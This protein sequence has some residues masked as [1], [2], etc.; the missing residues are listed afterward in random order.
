MMSGLSEI[1]KEWCTPPPPTSTCM[2]LPNFQLKFRLQ[3]EV[4]NAGWLIAQ[5]A[6]RSPCHGRGIPCSV[7]PSNMRL[8]SEEKAGWEVK[9]GCPFYSNFSRWRC[10]RWRRRV[11]L[12]RSLTGPSREFFFLSSVLS[13][14]LVHTPIIINHHHQ[15]N[16]FHIC[17]IYIMQI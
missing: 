3:E 14:S 9:L 5:Q 10:C 15:K 2:C 6:C 7:K 11:G 17:V 4:S 8:P 13:A 1:L 12:L 16:I